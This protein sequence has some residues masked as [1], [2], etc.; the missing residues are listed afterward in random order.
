MK[1]IRRKTGIGCS[2]PTGD[3]NGYYFIEELRK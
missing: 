1:T 3:G 2:S